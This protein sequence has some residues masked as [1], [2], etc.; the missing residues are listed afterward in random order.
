MAEEGKMEQELGKGEG[1][2]NRATAGIVVK[3]SFNITREGLQG[4]FAIM[5]SADGE[6]V[7]QGI[8]LAAGYQKL[9]SDLDINSDWREFTNLLSSASMRKEV[10]QANS[11]RFRVSLEE[12]LQEKSPNRERFF[13]SLR[14]Q[15]TQNEVEGVLKD[16]FRNLAAGEI[17]LKMF[18][19]PVE[20]LN[21]PSETTSESFQEVEANQDEEKEGGEIE[22]LIL[23]D[24]ISGKSASSLEFGDRILVRVDGEKPEGLS[25]A[26]SIGAYENDKMQ[27]VAADVILTRMDGKEFKVIAYFIDHHKKCIGF[28]E[29]PE[30]MVRMASQEEL[31]EPPKEGSWWKPVAVILAGLIV[32]LVGIGIYFIFFR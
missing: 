19:Q 25:F 5:A 7:V 2:Q 4:F 31:A 28:L 27:P 1:K 11:I 17:E 15:N 9:S 8:L 13:A 18:V 29:S 12:A 6:E 21:R 26:K 22:V 32:V 20:T 10:S 14:S 30:I 16:I 23:S 3:G 24:P